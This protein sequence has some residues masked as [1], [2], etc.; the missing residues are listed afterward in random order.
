MQNKWINKQIQTTYKT[1][2][3]FKHTK[4]IY[5][6]HHKTQ[7]IINNL[8]LILTSQMILKPYGINS[9]FHQTNQSIK[10]LMNLIT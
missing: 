9:T 7:N 5:L 4:N 3:S 1:I 6:N 2:I 8:N 10:L